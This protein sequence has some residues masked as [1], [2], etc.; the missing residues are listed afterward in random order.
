MGKPYVP[1]S[2]VVGATALL[3]KIQVDVRNAETEVLNYLYTQIDASSFK[4]NK[5]SAIVNT[6]CQYVTIG[7]NYTARVFLSATD[8]TQQPVIIVGGENF[9]STKQVKVFIP[10]P[11][12]NRCKI[13]GRY[14]TV[15][16]MVT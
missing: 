7:S 2:F 12:I 15:L 4:F 14:F 16:P 5:L 13:L 11:F 8:T 9:L 10:V 1:N 3:S 6:R